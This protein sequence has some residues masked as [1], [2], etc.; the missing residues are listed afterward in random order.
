M[1]EHGNEWEGR[2]KVGEDEWMK[3]KDEL[4]LSEKED[5]GM[6]GGG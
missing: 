2:L 1:G 6:V 5:S 4:T 3:G